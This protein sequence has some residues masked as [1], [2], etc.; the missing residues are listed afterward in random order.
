MVLKAYTEQFGLRSATWC[1]PAKGRGSQA[2]LQALN[3]VELVAERAVAERDLQTS[4]ASCAWP[5]PTPRSVRPGARRP[6]P[7]SCRNCCTKCCAAKP[8]MPSSYAFLEEALE[9]MDTVADV[10]HFPLVFLVQLS[11]HLGFQPRHSG[12][13]RGPFRPARRRVHA[14]RAPHG[15]TL[16]PPLSHAPGQPC[17]TVPLRRTARSRD[18]HRPTARTAGPSCCSTTACIWRAWVSCALRPYLHQVLLAEDP[19]VL[20]TCGT[21]APMFPRTAASP[22][23][24]PDRCGLPERPDPMT[25]NRPSTAPNAEASPTRSRR[26]AITA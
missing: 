5:S 15:H 14:R 6:S 3:R 26:T 8:P 2:A 10:R 16:G 7:C 9:V 17:L 20:A 18:P 1:V 22:L 25:R 11:G 24:G 19:P 12:T 21:F 23:A 4:C 13:R